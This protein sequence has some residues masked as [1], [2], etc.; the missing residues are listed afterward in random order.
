MM[1]GQNHI[2]LANIDLDLLN[3]IWGYQCGDLMPYRMV[4]LWPPFRDTWPFHH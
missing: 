4:I 3:E 2:K 1:H